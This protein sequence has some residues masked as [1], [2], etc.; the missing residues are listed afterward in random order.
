M[1]K[2]SLK[3]FDGSR[4]AELP[5]LEF[6]VANKTYADDIIR[7]VSADLGDKPYGNKPKFNITIEPQAT[8]E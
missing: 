7:L 6:Y 3:L 4:I 1:Y 8:K 2:V 5:F